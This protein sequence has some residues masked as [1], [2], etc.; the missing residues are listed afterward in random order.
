MHRR[1]KKLKKQGRLKDANDNPLYY[2][3]RYCG[4]LVER[5]PTRYNRSLCRSCTRLINAG[6][7][8]DNINKE[9]EIKI[10]GRA[11]T[12]FTIKDMRLK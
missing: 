9:V 5:K 4:V 12:R 8:E 7:V 1:L 6:Y 2:Y 10:E 3:C 11:P